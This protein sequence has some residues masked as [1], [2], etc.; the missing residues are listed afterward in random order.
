MENDKELLKAVW[1]LLDEAQIVVTQN[2]VRFDIKKLN[3]RFILNGMRPPSPF[4]N[5]DTFILA[6]SKFGFTSNK[7]EY[8]A[9]KL[10]KKYKKLKHQ[11]YAGFELWRACLAGDKDAWKEMEKYNKY[12]VLVL[13]ELYNIL[14]PWANTV[15]FNV[16]TEGTDVVCQCGSKHFEKRGFSYTAS[17]KF[18]KYCCL[19]CGA[20][21]SDKTNLLSKEKVKS[22]RKSS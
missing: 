1:A 22:L 16:Y 5:I 3:A 17:G 15:N 2:G 18:Q 19:E 7:L 11:K 20:W 8:M 13:E 4:K 10:C 6:K 9:D 21:T 14:A 12:D